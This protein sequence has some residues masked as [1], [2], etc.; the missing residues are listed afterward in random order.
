MLPR[1]ARQFICIEFDEV[2]MNEAMGNLQWPFGVI[3][4]PRVIACNTEAERRACEIRRRAERKAEICGLLLLPG[5]R[6]LSAAPYAALLFEPS[7]A[8]RAGR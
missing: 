6:V 2:I 1:W 7:P 3:P 8:A 4:R 5:S